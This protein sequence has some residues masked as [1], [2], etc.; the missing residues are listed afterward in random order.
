V[1]NFY[2]L[3][4]HLVP[5]LSRIFLVQ[6]PVTITVILAV[7]LALQLPKVDNTDIRTKLKR[8]DFAGAITLVSTTF[9]L[10][11]GLDRA[12]NVSWDD[13]LTIVSLAAFMV[14]LP[15]FAIIEIKI[16]KEPFAPKR[17]ILDPSLIPSFLVNFFGPSTAV[18][19]LFDV[20]LYLQAVMHTTAYEAGVWML[21]TVAGSISG[22]LISGLVL[23]KTGKY[24]TATLVA[25]LLSLWKP[26]TY[27]DYGD[28][29]VVCDWTIRWP[30]FFSL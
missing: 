7:S 16:A 11:F 13:T 25:N 8:V 26:T 9:C 10:L 30:V 27:R 15:L 19:L 29:E 3:I 6:V 4:T 20:T 5:S 2:S 12:A 1:P 22:S 14:L 23:Q 28:R 18:T 21:P 17:I 24:Y